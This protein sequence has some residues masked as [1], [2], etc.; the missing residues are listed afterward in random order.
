[1]SAQAAEIGAD[2][3]VRFHH[4]VL[5]PDDDDPDA[6]IVGRP[7]LGEFVELPSVCG[8]VI[9][10]LGEGRRV[11]DV[12]ATI[13]AEHDVELDTAGFVESLVDLAFVSDVDGRPLSTPD[14]EVPGGH[15]GR[16]TERHVRWVFAKPT[17]LLW[18]AVVGAALLTVFTHAD[19]FPRHQDFFWSDYVGLSVLVNTAFFSVFATIHEMMHLAAARSL[20]APAR[21]GFST[22]LHYLVVQTDVTAIWGVPRRQRYRVYLAGMVCDVFLIATMLLL[23]AYL[24]MSDMTVAILR[25]FTLTALLSLPLQAQIYMR[26]DLYFVLRDLLHCKD[27]FGDGLGYVRYLLV[28]ATNP[29]RRHRGSPAVDPTSDLATRERRA[30]R[31]YAVALGLGSAIALTVFAFYGAPIIISVLAH[32]LAAIWGGFHGASV[33]TAIDA[34]LLVL[35][36]GGIQVLF[37]AMF[38]RGHRH[39]FRVGRLK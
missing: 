36:E 39:W 12:E 31:I 8:E 28:R 27:L 32:S 7:D 30:V 23:V 21:I 20:G 1:M 4:L 24:P 9:R 22:R 15:F 34:A 38:V 25:A 18:L 35:V 5:R 16:L 37:L 6:I 3:I 29:I 2:S 14:S 19:L 13:A 10:L 11:R 33:L 17:K 26:T